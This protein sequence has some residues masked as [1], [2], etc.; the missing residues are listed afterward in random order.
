MYV[1]VYIYN[2]QRVVFGYIIGCKEPFINGN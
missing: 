1:Y 2:Q